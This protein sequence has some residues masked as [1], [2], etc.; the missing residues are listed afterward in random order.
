MVLPAKSKSR[1]FRRVKKVTPGHKNVIHYERRKP[2]K[3]VCAKTGE[4]LHGV[5]RATPSK[6][7]NMPKTMKRPERPYGGVL[8]SKAM[9]EVMK[10]K[11]RKSEL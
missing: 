10:E 2:S 6:M 11:A 9:R 8:S 3:A 5:A 1:T 7:Q 4:V